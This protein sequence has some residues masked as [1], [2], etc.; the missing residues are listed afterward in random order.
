MLMTGS[1]WAL[2][3]LLHSSISHSVVLGISVRCVYPNTIFS[4]TNRYFIG[5]LMVQTAKNRMNTTCLQSPDS[6]KQT[7]SLQMCGNGIVES[8]EDCDPGIGT[9]STCCDVSTCRFTSGAVCDPSSS[10]C[11]TGECQY[12]PSTQVCR[13]SVDATCDTAETCTGSSSACPTNVFSPNGNIN[14]LCSLRSLRA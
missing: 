5:S 3:H 10:P 2:L 8:G 12:A 4:I 9:N 13:P 1:L 6:T 14:L 11:C 7:I